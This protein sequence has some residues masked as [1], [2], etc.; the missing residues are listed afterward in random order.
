MCE[1]RKKSSVLLRTYNLMKQLVAFT[2][3]AQSGKTT[4][5]N[6][7]VK[8]FGFIRCSFATPIRMML[9]TLGVTDEDMRDRKHIEHPRL[10]GKTPREAMQTLGTE[11]ARRHI[12]DCLWVNQMRERLLITLSQSDAVLDDLRFDNEAQMI[13]DLGGVII[14]IGRPGLRQM[15]HESERGITASLVD[16]SI[17]NIGPL[18]DLY[19]AVE[20]AALAPR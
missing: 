10:C 9:G 4:A 13:K 7:L 18:D 1:V 8:K 12:G 19:E 16:A 20:G 2:G 14:H 11:W 3:L 5:S 6:F 15:Q 17:F